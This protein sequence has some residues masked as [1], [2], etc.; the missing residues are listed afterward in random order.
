MDSRVLSAR[1]VGRAIADPE[2]PPRVWLQMSTATIYAHRFD[3]A[4]DEATG[5]IGGSEPDVPD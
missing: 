5:M 2:R 1:A 4:N 3:A